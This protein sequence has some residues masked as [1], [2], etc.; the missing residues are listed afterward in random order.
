MGG[1]GLTGSA[2]LGEGG[3]IFEEV[4]GS[5]PDI[6]GQGKANPTALLFSA[7]M[8]LDH[9]GSADIAGHIREA[10]YKTLPD[11]SVCTGD[12]G[13]KGSTKSYADAVISRL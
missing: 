7:C 10:I 1:L 4:H 12:I 9:I 11:K 5:A 2:N 13:G 8:M 3:A 6:A